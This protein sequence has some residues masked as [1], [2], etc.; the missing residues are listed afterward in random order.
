MRQ[1]KRERDETETPRSHA[2]WQTSGGLLMSVP[3]EQVEG[4]VA[5]LRASG[6]P[7]AAIGRVTPLHEDLPRINLV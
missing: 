5:E 6:L 1:N 4:L 7:A 3:A 2:C